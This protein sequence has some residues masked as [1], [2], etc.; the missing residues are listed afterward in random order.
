MARA[1]YSPRRWLCVIG[2]TPGPIIGSSLQS[3]AVIFKK[4]FLSV[5]TR[6][7][8]THLLAVCVHMV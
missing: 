3:S 1:P 2:H 7:L 4:R 5:Y 6:V 8:N